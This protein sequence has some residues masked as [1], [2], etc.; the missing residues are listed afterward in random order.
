[1]TSH[2][3]PSSLSGTSPADGPV[4][5]TDTHCH[6]YHRS[7]MGPKDPSETFKGTPDGLEEVLERSVRAGVRRILMPAIDMESLVQMERLTELAAD[8]QP[9]LV[10]HPMAGI[11]PCE[12]TPGY[13]PPERELELAVASAQVIAVGETGLDGHWSR[14]AMAEQ[15]ISLRF[16]CRLAR[17]SGKPIVLHNRETTDELL[18]IIEQEQDGRLRGVW[19]CF[20]G[21]REQGLRAID[22]GLHLGIGGVVTFARAGVAEVVAQLPLAS[23][24]L[25]TDAPYLAPTP[26]RGRRN[27]P[28]Y[29]PHTATRLAEAVGVSLPDVAEITSRN[30]TEL[31]RL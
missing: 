25:E 8:L 22:L 13:R 30:A 23:M 1:M 29:L 16:H 6:L 28:S 11:H 14:E 10:L 26:H 7:F 17:E 15:E 18:A 3:D 5:L 24:V 21:T 9:D 31:F 4:S 12:V 2:T 27:E 20:N 19:H